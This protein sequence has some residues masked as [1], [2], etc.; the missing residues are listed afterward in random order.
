[1]S[2]EQ[3]EAAEIVAL[4]CI[5]EIVGDADLG[6]R[7]FAL[8]GLDAASL[9]EHLMQHST[10]GAALEFLLNH[11]PTLMDVANRLDIAPNEIV[12]AASTLLRT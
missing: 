10:L 4:R 5:A 7:F 6:P 8:T 11:E 1:M 12:E 3:I 9:R 2:S